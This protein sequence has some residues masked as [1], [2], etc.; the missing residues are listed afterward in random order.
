MDTA[1]LAAGI[2]ILESL[3]GRLSAISDYTASTLGGLQLN[4]GD[5]YGDAFAKV[6]DP[7][8][9]QI[10]SGLSDGASAFS[11]TTDGSMKMMHNYD[12]TGNDTTDMAGDF[13]DRSSK[14]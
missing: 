3:A 10:L 14:D 9:E 1:S 6:N 13:L 11:D 2:P 5:A 12:T 4:R 7:L 8:S